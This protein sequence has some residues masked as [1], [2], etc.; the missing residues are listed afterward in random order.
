M[1]KWRVEIAERRIPYREKIGL[2]KVES[3]AVIS[4]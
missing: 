3:E 1:K 4:M 2:K